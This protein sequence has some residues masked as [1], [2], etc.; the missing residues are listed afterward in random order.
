MLFNPEGH[1][2]NIQ[3]K[4]LLKEFEKSLELSFQ[5]EYSQVSQDKPFEEF[6][7]HAKM[8][9][10]TKETVTGSKQKLNPL[11]IR[12]ECFTPKSQSEC[13][14]ITPCNSQYQNSPKSVSDDCEDFHSVLEILS[15][16]SSN[17]HSVPGSLPRLVSEDMNSGEISPPLVSPSMV[18]LSARVST[19]S[20]E[21][22]Q[23]EGALSESFTSS[24]SLEGPN[25]ELNTRCL[26]SLF[27]D[28]SKAV[29]RLNDDLF[30]IDFLPL[31]VERLTP[32]SPE[33][34]AKSL[35]H[36]NHSALDLLSSL[37]P[38]TSDP[39]DRFTCPLI[40]SRYNF[41]EISQF[42]HYQFDTLRRAK[43]SSL[44]LLYYLHNP[45][46]TTYRPKCSHCN[47]LIS[48][49]RWHCEQCANYELCKS[50][51]ESLAKQY[52]QTIETK[53]SVRKPTKIIEWKGDDSTESSEHSFHPHPLVPFRV[54]FR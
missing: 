23:S 1:I 32:K 17:F 6:L 20:Y 10:N 35:H 46:D 53:P 52:Q 8:N 51:K 15:S 43:H 2:V 49:L 22:T 26:A 4:L 39:D 16:S 18:S 5:E 9:S 27:S 21:E 48:D 30:V 14:I 24:D 40:D 13:C 54:T 45:S 44:L 25:F 42:R 28:L 31:Q 36:L 33:D 50:C 3:A 47:C 37:F 29:H 41:L 12:D 34:E 19:S 38:D 11:K 7:A